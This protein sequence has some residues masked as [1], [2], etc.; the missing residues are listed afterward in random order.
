MPTAAPDVSPGALA[1]LHDMVREYYTAKLARHGARPRGVDWTCLPS[2]ELR[3]VQLLK[4]CDFSAP[5][6]LN[7]V[8]CGYG[9]LLAFLA[10]RHTQACID[11]LGIDLAPAMVRRARRLWRGGAGI[12][13]AAAGVPPRVADY[14]VASG[15]FNVRL[16]REVALWEQLIA[17]TLGEMDATSRCGFA[18]NLM[19]PRAGNEPCEDGL[20]RSPP[21]PWVRYCETVLGAGVD[22]IDDYGLR[23]F[24]L[25]VRRRAQPTSLP[26]D[27]RSRSSS[28]A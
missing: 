6:S 23:E 2:Q 28:G 19:A 4:L 21:D 1:P 12:A 15:I 14:S 24:T 5:F 20:Y 9:A 7:D 22:V 25:L 16:G 11:Y 10:K 8:G 17:R 3:F 18:F 26:I 13:F 27:A